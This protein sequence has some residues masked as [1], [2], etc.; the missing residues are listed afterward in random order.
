VQKRLGVMDQYLSKDPVEWLVCDDLLH[1]P[2]S[3]DEVVFDPLA[4]T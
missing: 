2:F 3:T 1:E 4:R